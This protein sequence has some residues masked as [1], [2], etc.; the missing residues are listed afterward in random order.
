MFFVNGAACGR[1]RALLMLLLWTDGTRRSW[2]RLGSAR[3]GVA[4]RLRGAAGSTGARQ[5]VCGRYSI[6]SSGTATARRRWTTYVRSFVRSLLRGN[7]RHTRTT[8]GLCC[9]RREVSE[10]R[11]GG[12][13]RRIR[14]ASPA[15]YSCFSSSS[16]VLC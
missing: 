7:S 11:V 4:V 6:L 12:D 10:I 14:P 5:E 16:S 13:G 2:T 9:A 1:W 8:G 15:V 3:L